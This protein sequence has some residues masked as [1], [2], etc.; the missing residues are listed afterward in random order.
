MHFL[1]ILINTQGYYY[2]Q[3]IILRLSFQGQEISTLSYS[4]Y[5][6]HCCNSATNENHYSMACVACNGKWVAI[7]AKTH[8]SHWAKLSAGRERLA[9]N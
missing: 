1:P 3:F 5:I 2:Y 6:I 9:K 8:F 7:F 4:T